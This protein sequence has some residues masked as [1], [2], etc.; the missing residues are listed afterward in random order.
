M[1]IWSIEIVNSSFLY[2]NYLDGNAIILFKLFGSVFASLN[3]TRH[4]ITI[5]YFYSVC[6]HD[7]HHRIPQRNFGQFIMFWDIVF[8]SFHEYNDSKKR[9]EREQCIANQLRAKEAKISSLE[10]GTGNKQIILDNLAELKTIPK[11]AVITGGNGMVGTELSKMLLDKGCNRIY[12]IDI[13][14]PS[15]KLEEKYMINIGI[16]LH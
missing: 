4:A 9:R 15:L 14:G 16:E 12:S 2:P 5:P 10:S 1:Y 11:I 8:G 13:A 6:N 7:V 3:H